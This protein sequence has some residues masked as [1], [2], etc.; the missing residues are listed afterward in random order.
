MRTWPRLFIA[1][2]AIWSGF[3]ADWAMAVVMA[4]MVIWLSWTAMPR[5][6]FR[7]LAAVA[8]AALVV[9]FAQSGLPWWA[10][11]ASAVAGVG[12]VGAVLLVLVVRLGD[13]EPGTS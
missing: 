9:D 2:S 10:A 3:R 1:G 6:I 11:L 5:S 4:V 8:G 13:R 12:L 7:V